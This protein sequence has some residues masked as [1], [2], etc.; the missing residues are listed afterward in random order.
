MEVPVVWWIGLAAA[1]TFVVA[2]GPGAITRTLDR[3]QP[4]DVVILGPGTHD[5]AVEIGS[6]VTGVVLRG[7]PD[8]IAD[9]PRERPDPRDVAGR[10]GPGPT[11]D[12]SAP[13]RG[14][15]PP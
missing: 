9:D 10:C 6:R 3:T 4:G 1:E 8:A 7:Q 14:V 13:H 11:T 12:A 2:P 15:P 5:E